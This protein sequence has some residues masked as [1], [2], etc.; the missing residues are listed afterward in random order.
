MGIPP[1]SIVLLGWSMVRE[2]HTSSFIVPG[3]ETLISR[4][5]LTSQILDA[6]RTKNLTFGSLAKAI[7]R[8]PV[9]TAALCYGQ[10]SCSAEEA[11]TLLD[12]LGL[13]DEIGRAHV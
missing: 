13:A 4:S 10:A 5:Q 9:W 12:T 2:S 6:K 3:A 8:H 11:K 7:G 1:G